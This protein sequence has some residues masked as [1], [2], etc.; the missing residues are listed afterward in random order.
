[1][2]KRWLVDYVQ[3]TALHQCFDLGGGVV[4]TQWPQARKMDCVTNLQ[5]GEEKR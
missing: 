1:M 3:K 4:F 5:L 2:C